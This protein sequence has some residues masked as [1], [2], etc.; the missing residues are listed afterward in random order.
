MSSSTI[1]GLEISLS[2]AASSTTASSFPLSPT[3]SPEF[4]FLES[5]PRSC[6]G[7]SSTFF[8][9]DF[10]HLSILLTFTS[11]GLHKVSVSIFFT[12]PSS[13]LHRFVVLLILN[14]GLRPPRIFSMSI[15][16]FLF[17]LLGFALPGFVRYST[18]CKSQIFVVPPFTLRG[19]MQFTI[20]PQVLGIGE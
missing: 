20:L 7:S 11:V 5:S 13:Y 14:L 2:A 16:R 8:S 17:S 10:A 4:L 12:A 19:D 18:V 6:L 15:C 9:S 3:G 1:V